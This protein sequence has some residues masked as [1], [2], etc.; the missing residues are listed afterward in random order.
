MLADFDVPANALAKLLRVVLL[1]VMPSTNQLEPLPSISLG[2]PDPTPAPAA[3]RPATDLPSQKL[4]LPSQDSCIVKSG[5]RQLGFEVVFEFQRDAIAFRDEGGSSASLENLPTNVLVEL[6]SHL[7]YPA[8]QSSAGVSRRMRSDIALRR[9]MLCACEADRMALY[10]ALNSTYKW[11][12]LIENEMSARDHTISDYS[13][14][15]H[16]PCYG[17]LRLRI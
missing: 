5:W 10:Q 9:T 7:H 15:H 11:A 16:L 12:G 2:S 14:S 1:S 13:E 4:R 8:I 3:S 17:C 6:A